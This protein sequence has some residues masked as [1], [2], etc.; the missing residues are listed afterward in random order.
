MCNWEFQIVSIILS[1]S[2][3]SVLVLIKIHTISI[4]N[5][6]IVCLWRQYKCLA[7]VLRP[8]LF[9]FT[10]LHIYCSIYYRCCCCCDTDARVSSIQIFV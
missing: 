6:L 1:I 2:A 5:T 10:A 8:T 7:H 9:L 4:R 3:M